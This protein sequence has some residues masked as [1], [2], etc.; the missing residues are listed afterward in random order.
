MLYNK[1]AIVGVH[2]GPVPKLS[3][4]RDTP[5]SPSKDTFLNA[6]LEI[7]EQRR[8]NPADWAVSL[9]VHV[10]IIAALIMIPIYLAPSFNLEQFR[11]TY[12]VAPL[13]PP[14]AAPPA[15]A[16]QRAVKPVTRPFRVSQLTMPTAI[17]KQIAIVKEEPAVQ[18]EIGG[19]IGGVPG[20]SMEGVLGGI[21]GNSSEPPPPP[22]AKP[23]VAPSHQIVRV[24]GDVKPPRRILFVQP[25]Y[26]VLARQGRIQ[27]V[28]TVDAVIDEHGNVVQVH[29]VDGQALLIPAA[30]KAVMQWKYEPTYLNG[31][32]V[33]LELH[34]TVSFSL[35]E[36]RD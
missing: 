27:G 12:L 10:L 33:P 20:G 16:I 30:M 32:A 13:P 26:P 18:P 19:V 8:R 34:A 3:I 22:A 35:G 2:Y 11:L 6:L 28:V 5:G 23:A 17:P 9:A 4:P 1:L 36:V 15:P 24:G 7:P 25:E 21:I 14:A 31:V 29:A